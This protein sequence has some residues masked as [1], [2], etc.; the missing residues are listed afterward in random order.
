M[1]RDDALAQLRRLLRHVGHLEEHRARQVA[2][3]KQVEVYVHVV[4]RLPSALRLLLLGVLVLE[5]VHLDTLREELLHPRR[6]HIPEAIVRVA[7]QALAECA[8]PQRHHH[9]VVQN[10]R[11][12]VGLADVV[13]QVAHEEEVARRVEAVVLRVVR[14][15][16]EHGTRTASVVSVLVHRHAQEAQLLRVVRL[17]VH[18]MAGGDGGG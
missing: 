8:Q 16:A 13:L 9:A 15:M 4:W 10:L 11:R 3:L 12:D 7:D 5:P 18:H 17:E 14:D 1:L 2:A 6:A